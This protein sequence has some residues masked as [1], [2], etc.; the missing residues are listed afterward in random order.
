MLEWPCIAIAGPTATGKTALA[1]ELAHKL[2]SEVFSA[3]SRQVYR[4]LDL[5]TGKDLQEY[6]RFQ[7]PVPYHLVDIADPGEVYSLFRYQEDCH[8]ALEDFRRRRGEN[9]PP[10]LVGGT[11]LYLEAVLRR[12]D[13]AQVPENSAL[14]GELET[15]ETEDLKAELKVLDPELFARS[16]LSTKRRL[17]RALEVALSAQQ[18]EIARSR[19]PEWRLKPLVFLMHWERGDLRVRIAKRLRAR[20]QAGLVEEVRRLQ[21]QGLSWD[22]LD[23]LGMEYRHV[24]A[25]LR[26]EKDSETLEADLLRDIRHFAKRQDTYFRGMGRRGVETTPIG[27]EATA[28]SLAERYYQ[29]RKGFADG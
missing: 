2:G 22:R 15:R 19:L 28:A 20:L 8:R 17:V 29:W 11:G 4:G 9:L 21:A 6:R 16:D 27:P 12:Y 14:R 18:G 23:A 5:G 25:H 24:A 7:P 13:I 26:G 10:I 1:A 3:D